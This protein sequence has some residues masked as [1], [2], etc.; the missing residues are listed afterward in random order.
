MQNEIEQF[1][2]MTTRE[3]TAYRN[4]L[5]WQNCPTTIMDDETA[6][7]YSRHAELV[8]KVLAARKPKR[9]RRT[10]KADIYAGL[11]MVKV[12]GALGGTYYE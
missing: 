6:K 11:G 3:L 5:K 4:I 2:K 8:D 9:K 7:K 1:E 10:S 12:R